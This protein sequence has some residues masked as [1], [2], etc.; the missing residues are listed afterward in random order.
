VAEL[1]R[2]IVSHSMGGDFTTFGGVCKQD[3]SAL[4]IERNRRGRAAEIW[5]AVAA[6]QMSFGWT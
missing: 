2:K 3:F 4:G 1:K 6:A 5:A